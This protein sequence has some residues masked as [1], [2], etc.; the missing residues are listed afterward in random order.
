MSTIPISAL[1][2]GSD[3]VALTDAIIDQVVSE[4]AHDANVFL[5][6]PTGGMG[7]INWKNLPDGSVNWSYRVY[8]DSPEDPYFRVPGQDGV[9]GTIVQ[10]KKTVTLDDPFE[11]EL[12][13]S[14]DEIENSK[15]D[16]VEKALR[17]CVRKV[18]EPY[19]RRA[20]IV[21]GNA[22]RSAAVTNV[23][24]SGI[25]QSVTSTASLAAAY[26]LS[27]TGAQNFLDDLATVGEEY[28]RRHIP[29]SEWLAFVDPYII[30]VLTRS[31]KLM[32]RDYVPEGVT[33]FH[34]AMVGIAEGFQ[35]V[36][37]V[38]LPTT[39]VTTDLTKYNG[40]YAIGGSDGGIAAALTVPM[41][42]MRRAVCGVRK[43]A[44]VQGRVWWDEDTETWRT[45][46]RMR[47]G[48]GAVDVWTAGIIQVT[49]V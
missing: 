3:A 1:K 27:N 5:G 7:V 24:R 2:V 20:A 43:G 47:I 23:H 48:L 8:G 38:H 41:S 26:P 34:K 29:Q 32:N 18:T 35:L 16:E 28:R 17:E 42:G 37:T 15:W 21:L 33:A 19:D 36:P 46:A 13:V 31:D 25:E 22:A 11:H 9:S 14:E 6:E 44:T 39:D 40:D 4:E 30:T 45:K 12:H 49:S 10:A